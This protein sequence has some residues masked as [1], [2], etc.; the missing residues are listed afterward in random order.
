M[1]VPDNSA[2][3]WLEKIPPH[4]RDGVLI[5]PSAGGREFFRLAFY[6]DSILE[7]YIRR[8]LC[9]RYPGEEVGSLAKRRAI[10]A[11]TRALA[12]LAEKW[13]LAPLLVYQEGEKPSEYTL[14]SLTE[15]FVAAVA[16]TL[17][18]GSAREIG[19]FL[20]QFFMPYWDE[21][22]T[23]M[24]DYKSLVQDIL[25]RNHRNFEYRLMGREGPDH[26][27]IYT[28]C[29]LVEGREVS[30]GKGSS[31]RDAEQAAAE[32]FLEGISLPE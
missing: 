30:T 10:L 9:Q 26:S 7:V 6:G 14:A 19:E 17:G 16:M 27:P 15:A 1:P 31:I 23:S 8:N 28:V 11:S 2:L 22:L 25:A 21:I 20:N 5:H 18:P 32:D 3:A 29:L 4:L 12:F 13:G 24:A